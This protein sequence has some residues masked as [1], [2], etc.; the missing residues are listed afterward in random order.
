M[1][2]FKYLAV[3]IVLIMFAT[4]CGGSGSS[5][6]GN[7]NDDR[8]YGVETGTPQPLENAFVLVTTD[9]GESYRLETDKDGKGY[10]AKVDK[11]GNPTEKVDVQ[12]SVKDDKTFEVSVTLSGGNAVTITGSVDGDGRVVNDSV[13]I[14]GSTVVVII[15]VMIS[16][17]SESAA[18][19]TLSASWQTITI[20]GFGKCG[21]YSTDTDGAV[22][23]DENLTCSGE[24][25]TLKFSGI[26]YKS[27][28]IISFRVVID[29]VTYVYTGGGGEIG[30]GNGGGGGGSKDET[31]PELSI[32]P[33]PK[34]YTTAINIS[35]TADEDATIY[36]TTDGSTP[37][38]SSS[39]YVS[40]IALSQDATIKYFGVDSA[41]NQSAIGE[42]AYVVYPITVEGPIYVEDSIDLKGVAWD[43]NNVWVIDSRYDDEECVH[44]K[45]NPADGTTIG[46]PVHT[47]FW[48]GSPT[49]Q[50]KFLEWDGSNFW[51]IQSGDVPR[52]LAKV[53]SDGTRGAQF[54]IDGVPYG[55]TYDGS[56]FT[57][58]DGN[59][60]TLYHYNALG[61]PLSEDV[62]WDVRGSSSALTWCNGSYWIIEV[63]GIMDR[64]NGNMDGIDLRFQPG[65]E[66]WPVVED[67]TCDAANK[68]IWIAVSPLTSQQRLFKVSLP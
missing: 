46:S 42:A 34:T 50:C 60:D 51:S 53:N 49:C 20:H 68:V 39:V 35:I 2:K 65:E 9:K 19:Y 64:V 57:V 59:P 23:F 13:K 37:T 67:A 26:T 52:S 44:F 10:V 54:D 15:I 25:H 66:A 21:D 48:P 31:P 22:S 36:Y 24:A 63:F 56:A 17:P 8:N 11:D 33:D 43:G 18:V 30:G 1:K 7:N 28:A 16:G 41:G 4:G 12:V 14:A 40:P 45:V 6:T 62:V 55:M 3:A 47:N 32:D 29:G 38:V 27:G 58:I 5:P 61:T